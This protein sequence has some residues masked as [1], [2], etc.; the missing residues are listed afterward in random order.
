M[1]YCDKCKV[2]VRGKET[3]CPLCQN[4]LTGTDEEA[5][6]PNIPTIYKQFELFFKLLILA[7]ITAGVT[8]VAINL[9]L[10]RHGYWSVFVVFGLL[11]F[12]LSLAY[13]VRRKDNLPKN[14]TFQAAM[15]SGLCVLWDFF[16]GWHGWSLDYVFPIICIAAMISLAVLSR[17]MRMP[18]GDYIVYLFVVVLFGI[19]P[20]ILYLTGF[21]CI[22]IPS[23]ICI[24]LSVVTLSALILFEGANMIAEIQKHFH[25]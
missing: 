15:V 12:W 7:T 20:F 17:V 16:T 14:I 3:V 25:V 1:K 24:G 9:I 22:I 10:P 6:Y 5:L 13:A 23:V 2:S 8:C 21:V 19:V 11:C 4:R 18:A